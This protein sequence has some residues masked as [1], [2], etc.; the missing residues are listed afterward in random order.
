MGPVP[1]L[2]GQR[3]FVNLDLSSLATPVSEFKEKSLMDVM[4]EEE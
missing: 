2:E 4:V 1:I 3:G